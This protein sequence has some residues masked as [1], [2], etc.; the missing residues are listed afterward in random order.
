VSLTGCAIPL[1]DA[2]HTA[3]AADVATTVI[4]TASGVAYEANPLV[5]SPAAA[6]V[7]IGARIWLVEH[8]DGWEE[9][10]RTDWLSKING[11]W[12]GVVISNTM[13]IAS[14]SNPISFVA[15]ILGGWAVYKNAKENGK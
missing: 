8:I 1:R 2:A 14:F 5:S 6:L 12:W 7:L 3:T 9:P 13:I 4:G 10:R 15:G 11:V